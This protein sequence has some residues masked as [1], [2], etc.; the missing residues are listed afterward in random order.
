MITTVF[1]KYFANEWI[2]SWNSQDIEKIL[3]HYSDDFIIETPMA[4]K[5]LPE[6]GGIVRGKE[7]VKKYWTIGLEHI[8]NLKFE[9]LDVLIGVNVLSIY[10]L[11]IATN[12]KAIEIMSFNNELKVNR[13]TVL[14]S[15]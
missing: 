2:N 5:I 9:I 8:P 1:A 10:Y 11:N 12:K 15:E 6:T 13:A 4:I 14:Y 3:S 7:A